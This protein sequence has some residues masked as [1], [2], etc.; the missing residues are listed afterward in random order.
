MMFLVMLVI[1]L[2][3]GKWYGPRPLCA[4]SELSGF[5]RIASSLVIDVR[6]LPFHVSLHCL[7]LNHVIRDYNMAIEDVHLKF[8]TLDN[9]TESEICERVAKLRLG[10]H[11]S[12]LSAMWINLT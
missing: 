10:P 5:E 3:C 2:P 7:C 6:Q 8:F 11:V 9:R 4:E 12:A 1:L